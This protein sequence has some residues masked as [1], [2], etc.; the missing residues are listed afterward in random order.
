[1]TMCRRTECG[2]RPQLTIKLLLLP[3]TAASAAVTELR[4]LGPHQAVETLRTVIILIFLLLL[5]LLLLPP[6]S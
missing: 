6:L 2:A 4:V 3:T 1:M 5:L